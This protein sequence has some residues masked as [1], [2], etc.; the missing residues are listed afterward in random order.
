MFSLTVKRVMSTRLR[1]ACRQSHNLFSIPPS[2]PP[3]LPCSNNPVDHVLLL[4]QIQV[5][6]Q[7][8]MSG[9]EEVVRDSM[10][11]FRPSEVNVAVDMI[12]QGGG[13]SSCANLKVS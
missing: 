10:E 5:N 3:S 4:T 9:R 12:E 6:K 1:V 8:L 7:L 11:D 13:R 2:L